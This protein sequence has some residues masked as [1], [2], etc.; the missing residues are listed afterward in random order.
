MKVI[1]VGKS[2]FGKAT[3]DAF[4]NRGDQVVLCLTPTSDQEVRTRAEAL[5]IPLG[6]YDSLKTDTV[7]NLVK[8]ADADIMIFSYV[9]EYIPSI[10]ATLPKHGSLC[11]HPS[12][13]PKYRGP[14]AIQWAIINGETTTGVSLFKINEHI[15]QGPVVYQTEIPIDFTDNVYTFFVNK[16]L[17]MGIP[18]ILEGAD[19]VVSEQSIDVIQDEDLAHYERSVGVNESNVNWNAHG[20]SIYNLIRGCDPMP[21]AWTTYQGKAVILSN[22]K[23]ERIKTFRDI[24]GRPGQVLESTDTETR[25][26]VN[27]GIVTVNKIEVPIGTILT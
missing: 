5:G 22:P 18:A 26:A 10:L 13:L 24:K 16:L 14:D 17:P 19:L 11:V 3:L 21:G 1:I 27:G 2:Y 23:F 12:L 20:I 7:Y 9:R 15:D 25:I 4:Y 6:L 8:N